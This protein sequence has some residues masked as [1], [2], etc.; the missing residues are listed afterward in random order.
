VASRLDTRLEATAPPR[1]LA[2]LMAALSVRNN[3]S[4]GEVDVKILVSPDGTRRVIVDIPGTKSWAPV[5][6]TPN[7]T[8]VATNIRAI[9]G[10]ETAYEKGVLEAMKQAG[11]RS[12]DDVMIVGHSLGGMV[13]VAAARDA[14]RS[15]RFNVTHVVTAGS[16]IAR[17]V[18]QLPKSVQVLALENKHDIVP[19]LDGSQNPD[20]TNVT[21]ATFDVDTGTIGDDH[22]IDTSYEPGA[23]EVDASDD[24]AIRTFLGGASGFFGA[25][26][27]QTRTY[28]ITRDHK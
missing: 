18:G 6:E 2:D 27:I 12:T 24:A 5:H 4:P 20:L 23:A 7:V 14:V 10:E 21:T 28:V 3:G 19:R 22:G 8:G 15:G 26:T 16:P 9:D 25:T 1:S 11:V 17:F 13:A